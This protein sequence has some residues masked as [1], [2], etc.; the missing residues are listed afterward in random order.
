MYIITYISP[1][2][3]SF[4]RFGSRTS[5][6]ISSRAHAR[7][8]DNLRPSRIL[9]L[10]TSPLATV[11][12]KQRSG[13]ATGWSIFKPLQRGV[14]HPLPRSHKKLCATRCQR[15]NRASI[16]NDNP[17]ARPANSAPTARPLPIFL[18]DDGILKPPWCAFH[19]LAP[20]IVNV[21]FCRVLRWTKPAFLCRYAA[22]RFKLLYVIF[23]LFFTTKN[24]PCL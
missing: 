11:T 10:I 6:F 15:P 8:F 2:V 1:F 4:F 24:P 17:T 22:P 18:Y 5:Y 23:D 3:N 16:S 21:L 9:C 19:E 20:W 13:W 7:L 14:R 12:P